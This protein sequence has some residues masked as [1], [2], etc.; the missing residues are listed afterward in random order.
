MKKIIVTVVVLAVL[1]AALGTAGLAYAQSPTPAANGAGSSLMGGRGPRGGMGAGVTASGEGF[2]HDAMIAVFAEK[3]GI[4]VAD[5]EARLANGETMAQIALSTG[6]TLDEF[7]TLMLEARSQA[8]DQAVQD[9]TLT[10]AQA[11]WMKQ[12]V[13]GQMGGAGGQRGGRMGQ[14]LNANCPYNT[15]TP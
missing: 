1:V 4:P 14:G 3:L 10:Q 13:G 7:R 5:L 8:I 15:T 2:L 12:H 9:G 6:L 11:D